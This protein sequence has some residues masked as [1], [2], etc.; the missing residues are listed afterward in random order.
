MQ[1][2]IAIVGPTSSGKTD[3]SV[4]I[5][6]FLG[7][8]VVSAD[9]RQVYRG[10][11]IGTGKV[12]AEEMRGVPHHLLDVADPRER[13]TA[14]DYV[15]LGREAINN[16]ASRGRIPIVAGG[17]GF[18][19]DA[20]FGTVSLADA[21]PNEDLRQKLSRLDAE[22][23]HA[24]LTH[25]DHAVALRIDR[26]NKA[27][28]IRA[29]EVAETLGKVPRTQSET[30]YDTLWIGLTLPKEK[31]R[32]KIHTRLLARMEAGMLDEVRKLHAEGLSYERMEEL[33]LE[34]RYL[35]RHLTGKLS[36]E[37][38]LAELEKEIHHYAKRQMT[39]FK[40]NKDIRWFSPDAYGDIARA[41]EEFLRA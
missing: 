17:T 34:Y 39:W 27:R 31:L 8:E 16:I 5:A 6:N 9:S 7:G 22:A 25:L 14:A 32:E 30:L 24:R 19:L 28:L 23:L 1:K 12:T 20:L 41:A 38:M 4:G 36:R 10:L 35:A 13:F 40:R 21:P 15:R 2:I 11:D 26:K 33:G 18:Y 37:R 3:V 29:I